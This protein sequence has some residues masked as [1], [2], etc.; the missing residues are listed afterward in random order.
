MDWDGPLSLDE[1]APSVNVPEI[2]VPLTGAQLDVLCS[3]ISP[4]G[5]SENYGVDIYES[6]VQFLH[7]YS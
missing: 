6:V 7:N 5:F 2:V 4:L 1:D 3:A